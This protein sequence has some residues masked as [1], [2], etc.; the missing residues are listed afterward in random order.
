MTTETN[1]MNI[2]QNLPDNLKIELLHYAEYL[3]Y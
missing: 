2:A 1:L 3:I